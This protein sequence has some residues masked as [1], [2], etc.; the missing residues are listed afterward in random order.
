MH[1]T[2]A[3]VA[4]RARMSKTTTSVPL[5]PQ[6]PSPAV[7]Y[8]LGYEVTKSGDRA[9]KVITFKPKGVWARTADVPATLL[10]E[11]VSLS[12]HT[13]QVSVIYHIYEHGDSLGST[14]GD[15]IIHTAH[16]TEDEAMTNAKLL[17][18]KLEQRYQDDYFGSLEG[19]YVY[20][21]AVIKKTPVDKIVAV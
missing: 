18:A 12:T 7:Y 4:K 13:D 8:Y 9:A 20:T 16:A 10:V 3:M 14:R 5:T 1:N 21:T 19:V 6:Q 11:R 17:K 15:W 2:S